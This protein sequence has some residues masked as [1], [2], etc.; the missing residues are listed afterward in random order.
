MLEYIPPSQADLA[1]QWVDA[2]VAKPCPPAGQGVHQWVFW[3]CQRAKE[4]M[5]N[6]IDEMIIQA[7]LMFRATR[8]LQKNEISNAIGSESNGHSCARRETDKNA[9]PIPK[10]ALPKEWKL[11]WCKEKWSW[12][13]QAIRALKV[14]FEPNAPIS[15][16]C[17]KNHDSLP[18]GGKIQTRD[19]WINDIHNIVHPKWRGGVQ[20]RINPT[21]GGC[22]SDVFSHRYCL[23]EGDNM[24]I[25][26]QTDV[27]LESGLPIAMMCL[28]GGKSVHAWIRIDAKD[29]KEFHHRRARIWKTLENEGFEIDKGCCN[30]SRYSRLPG[31]FRGQKFQTLLA[32]GYGNPKI[33]WERK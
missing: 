26:E 17:I 19:E 32:L 9:L 13:Q 7:T 10:E 27:L 16:C 2:V 23:V 11:T 33:D 20:I 21:K 24:A 29:F 25:G 8:P 3:A 18:N 5:G 22:D 28:S 31:A 14:C 12:K 15:I 6:D 1:Q 30:P 4:I